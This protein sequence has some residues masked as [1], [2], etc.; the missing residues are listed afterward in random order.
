[1]NR[2]TENN[3]GKSTNTLR[4]NWAC[5]LLTTT[6][7][8]SESTNHRERRNRGWSPDAKINKLVELP[9][10]RCP[11]TEKRNKPCLHRKSG[12]DYRFDSKGLRQKLPTKWLRTVN[13]SVAPSFVNGV[14]SKRVLDWGG[15]NLHS[16]PQQNNLGGTE[17]LDK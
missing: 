11:V 3:R 9:E 6:L 10:G 5:R 2:V 17:K 8:P 1:V 16:H 14:T 15:V 13:P 4:R 7:P 12:G